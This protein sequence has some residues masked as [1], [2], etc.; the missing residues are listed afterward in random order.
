M[1]VLEDKMIMG[2]GRDDKRR[3]SSVNML[4]KVWV[5]KELEKDYCMIVFKRI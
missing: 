4:N 1:N 5:G 3:D 2:M